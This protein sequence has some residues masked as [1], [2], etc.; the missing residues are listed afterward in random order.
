MALLAS[1]ISFVF[2]Y[3][4]GTVEH[5]LPMMTCRVVHSLRDLS[6]DLLASAAAS[7]IPI[8]Q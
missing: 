6:Q 3:R 8:L 4:I 1:P 5:S 2:G 7:M